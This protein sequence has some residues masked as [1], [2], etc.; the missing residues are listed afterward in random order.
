MKPLVSVITVSYNAVSVIERT[1]LSVIGQNYLNL[2]YIIIDGGSVDGTIDIIKN[3]QDQISYWISESDGGIYDAMNKGLLQSKGKWINFM[4]AGDTFSDMFV[5]D[6]IF[7]EEIN[8]NV[9]IVY[10]NTALFKNGVFVESFENK[11]FWLSLMPFRGKGICHQSM[12][13]KSDLAKRMMFDT[14]YRI[15]SDYDMC[16]KIY[17]KGY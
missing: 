8:E 10:G 9:G 2:E 15:C 5:L 12:F 14:S 6:N 16:Y 1:I 17:K 4:N 3:Y 7:S 11:P 13:V